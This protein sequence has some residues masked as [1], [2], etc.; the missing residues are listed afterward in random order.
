MLPRGE[1]LSAQ[2]G[3]GNKGRRHMLHQPPRRNWW[4]K[5]TGDRHQGYGFELDP[6]DQAGCAAL[7]DLAGKAIN[8]V[9]NTV[10]QSVDHVKGFFERL[11]TELAF[12]GMCQ[13]LRPAHQN[14]YPDVLSHCDPDFLGPVSLSG[15]AGCGIVPDHH[16]SRHRQ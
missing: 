2:L 8:D 10:T 5:L 15:P 16:Q 4:D 7:N 11:R 3:L 14:R 13:S 9:A 12:T 6:R 1:L